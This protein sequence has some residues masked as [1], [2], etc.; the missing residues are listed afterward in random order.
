MP[1]AAAAV[2]AVVSTLGVAGTIAVGVAVVAAGMAYVT[3][4]KAKKMG[5]TSTTASSQKQMF[6]DA[7]APK[8]F[9][10]GHPCTSGPM[11]F[12]AEEGSPND[13]GAGE[14]LH[15]V[16]H[17]AGHPCEEVT[18]AWLNDESL[19]LMTPPSGVDIAFKHTNGSGWVYFY[20]GNHTTAPETLKHLPDWS[21]SMVGRNQC[22]AHIKLRSDRDKWPAG[23]PN[24]KCSVKGAKVFDPR[25]GRTQWTDNTALLMRW[26][27]NAIKHGVA[28]DESY[29]SA[30]NICDELV[31][32]PEGS[33]HRYRCNYAFPCDE[34]PTTVTEKIAATAAGASLRISGR[35]AFHVGAYYGPGVVEL[36]PDDIIGDIKTNPDIRRRD[37]I[38]TVTAKYVDPKS[39]WNTVDMPRVQHE[40]YLQ[41]DSI[42][43]NDDLDLECCPS[44]FQAQRIAWIHL[45]TIREGFSIDIPCNMRAAELLPGSVFKLTFPENGWDGLEFKVEKWKLVH[46]DGITL[47]CKQHLPENYADNATQKVPTRVAVPSKS[48]P[49]NVETPANLNYQQLFADNAAQALIAWSHRSFGGITYEVSFYKAGQLQRTETTLDKFYRLTDGF[50]TGNYEVRVRARNA[51]GGVSDTAVLAFSTLA[52]NKPVNCNV[53]ISN[54][55]ITMKPVPAGLTNLD[56]AYDFAFGFDDDTP[57]S[58]FSAHIQGRGRLLT[59]QGLKPDTTYRFA[60]REISRWGESPWYT[61]QAKTAKRSEDILEVI[62]GDITQEMLNKELNAH[63]NQIEQRGIDTQNLLSKSD[64]TND[65]VIAAFKEFEEQQAASQQKVG[66][67]YAERKIE[68]HSN[69]LSTQ[70]SEIA[71]LVVKDNENLAAA[72]EYT[73][74]AVGYCIDKNGNITNHDDAVACV[75]AGHQWHEGP[76]AEYIRNLT[77]S[78]SDKQ[79]ASINLLAQAFVDNEGKPVARGSMTTDVNGKVSG[80]IN[81]NDGQQTVLDFIARH[82]RIGDIDE[83]GK[84]VPALFVDAETKKLTFKGQMILGDGYKVSSE[85][86]IRALDGMNGAGFYTLTLRDGVFPSGELAS[87]DFESAYKRKPVQDDHLT[88]RNTDGDTSSTKRFNGSDWVTPTMLIHGDMVATGSLSGDR[89][90]AG[91]EISAPVVK[92]GFLYGSDMVTDANGMLTP[93]DYNQEVHGSAEVAELVKSGKKPYLAQ[94]NFPFSTFSE[95]V[96]KSG[97][98]TSLTSNNSNRFNVPK[99]RLPVA[100]YNDSNAENTLRFAQKEVLVEVDVYCMINRRDILNLDWGSAGN[101]PSYYL[102]FNIKLEGA[103]SG[104]IWSRFRKDK[105]IKLQSGFATHT[106]GTGGDADVFHLH[107]R[108]KMDYS[109]DLTFGLEFINTN[110]TSTHTIPDIYWKLEAGI[111]SQG[112]NYR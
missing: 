72:K 60:I 52:P 29:I 89:I 83:D 19:E 101:N 50:T 28:M 24:F 68:K 76:L 41:E 73:R 27:R 46:K 79:K 63:L 4:Q 9:I 49:A 96:V 98:V 78:M 110:F 100:P 44:A 107:I 99:L 39:S 42:E 65:D 36:T 7:V 5:K 31:D 56:T 74:S 77:V 45:R 2:A 55:S 81:S 71:Q 30:A 48:N 87:G 3:Y 80:F 97:N 66:F 8:Q 22:F 11:I 93:S 67:A 95:R 82:F 34:S 58:D 102:N 54:W 109:G 59:V 33:E 12:A 112:Q 92:G 94:L 90:A 61:G 111:C 64:G 32:T 40:G 21:S 16:V 35:H 91:T 15:I 13:K 57:E 6:R 26:Y 75:A 17:L 23:L 38:N 10:L 88:Y 69:E 20:L 47:Q 86:N 104:T 106:T 108:E 103:L 53:D 51:H 105:T 84:F 62:H 18:H 43:I 14:L 25:T 1:P 85:E 37:R 70:A